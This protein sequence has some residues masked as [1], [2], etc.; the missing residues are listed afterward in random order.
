[1]PYYV[2]NLLSYV[3]VKVWESLNMNFQILKRW[4]LATGL[5]DEIMSSLNIGPKAGE[6]VLIKPVKRSSK[7]SLPAKIPKSYS[8]Q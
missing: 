7:L 4:V 1:M 6:R 3:Q 2:P 5:L 8:L